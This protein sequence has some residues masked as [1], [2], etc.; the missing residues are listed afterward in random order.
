M[1][2]L[3]TSPVY[4]IYLL[5]ILLFIVKQSS[6]Q[7]ASIT[8]IIRDKENLMPIEDVVV[9]IEKTNNHTHTDATGSYSFLS[10]N[11]GTYDIDFIKIGYKKQHLTITVLDNENKKVDVDFISTAKNLSL[12]QIAADRPVSAA[13]STYLSQIDFENR[14]KN[15]AQDM[16][17]L[18]RSGQTLHRFEL[19]LIG[20]VLSFQAMRE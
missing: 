1:K 6:A 5:L 18:G 14:P 15:S 20:R 10:L 12:V 9:S 7:S 11:A 16:L 19:A 17:R 4:K 8:G 2:K 13:S 3:Y